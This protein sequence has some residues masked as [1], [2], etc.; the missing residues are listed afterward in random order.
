MRWFAHVLLLLALVAAVGCPSRTPPP[1]VTPTPE[2]P[3]DGNPVDSDK[4]MPKFN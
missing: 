3:K 1:K 4:G 2:N